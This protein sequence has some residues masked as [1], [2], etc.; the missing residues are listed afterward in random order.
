MLTELIV[1]NFAIIDRLQLSFAPGFNVLTGETG[2]GK[3]IIIDAIGLLLGDRARPDLIRHGEEEATVEALFDLSDRPD[4]RREVAEAGFE[5]SDELLVRRIVSRAG[6]NRLFINGSMAK[7]GQLQ[8][9]TSRLTAIYGQ[10]EH[11][12]LQRTETHLALLDEFAGLDGEL[13][14]YRH[15]HR[16]VAELT[17]RLRQLDQS[18]RDRRQ[19]L[20]LLSFQEREITAANLTP[21]EDEELAA[22]RSLLQNAGRLTA[23]TAGGYEKLYGSEGAVCET[24]EGIASSLEELAGVDPTLGTLAEAL[25]TSLFALED[26]ARQLRDYA[27]RIAF[28]PERQG[29]VE[30]RLAQI[31]VLKR[32]YAPSL[33]AI[34]EYRSKIETE[35]AE[36]SDSESLREGL[37]QR[38]VAARDRLEKAGAVLSAR[39]RE[40]AVR[41]REAVE[42]ELKDLALE[43]ARFEMRFFDLPEPGPSGVERGEFYLAPNPGEE[44]K[45]LAWIASGGEL[46]RIMLALQRAAPAAERI[47]TLVFDEV[48]AGI[49]G[50]AATAVGEKLRAVAR[51]AQVLCITHLPQVAAFGDRHYRVEK[52][53]E[54]GRT[55]TTVTPLETE[56]RV[57]EMARMLGGAMVTERTL[58]H[59]REMV[60]QSHA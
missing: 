33:P 9:I 48:D 25:R 54:G 50:A 43:K 51:G 14:A 29:E 4:L 32:K 52:R 12:R 6:K 60:A 13:G 34:L 21:G 41:L 5:E 10:H 30:D 38:I 15:F 44:T 3:S 56:E 45:P 36:L 59:A 19:R 22:E 24:V 23:A 7:L 28:E 35:I 16:E 18:E 53:E 46:S 47:P 8:P 17:A 1:R 37:Q 39:R 42:G 40:A 57:Q 27:G 58:E 55:F 26:V 11:Q 31:A 49:G 20:D 2:A